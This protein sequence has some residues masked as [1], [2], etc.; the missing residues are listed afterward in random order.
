MA[1]AIHQHE[2]PIG[3]HVTPPSWT[4]LLPP[5]PSHPPGGHGTPVLGSLCHTPN[6]HWLSILRMVM[7]TFPYYSLKPFHPL[8]LPLCPKVCSLCLWY[9]HP[10]KYY[11]ALKKN[12]FESVLMRWM[13]IEPIIQSE[14]SQKEKQIS[15]INAYIWNPGR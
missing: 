2:S 3:I 11:S 5:C 4:P 8:L 6:S 14:V 12:A 7:Y 9:I 15:Y 10:M 1:S 13:N